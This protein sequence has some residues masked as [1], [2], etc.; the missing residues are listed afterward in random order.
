MPAFRDLLRGVAEAW[1][2]RRAEV[3]GQGRRV[4][5]AIAK[6]AAPPATG[7]SLDRTLAD[8]AVAGLRRSFDA[9]WGGFGGAPKFPQPMTLE[10]LLRRAVRGVDGVLDMVTTTL[11]RM[12]GGGIYDQLGG[13]FARYSTDERWHVPHF[14][15]MLYDNAQLLQ[16]YTRAW[17]VT[18]SSR[19][20]TVA[21]ETAEYLLRE[22]QHPEGGFTPRRT[23]TRGVEGRF[24]TWSWAEPRSSSANRSRGR[25]GHARR[26]TGPATTGR[27]TCSGTRVRAGRSAPWISTRSISLPRSTTRG[28]CCMR[29]VRRVCGPRPTTRCSPPGTAWRSPPSQAGRALAEPAYTTAAERERRSSS[30]TFAERTAACSEPGATGCARNGLRRRPCTMASACLTLYETTFE[31]SWFERARELADDLRRLFADRERGGFFQTGSDAEALVVRPKDLYDN[32][33]PSGNSAAADLLRLSAFTGEVISRPMPSRR[34]E[35]SA[36]RSNAHPGLR[37]SALRPRPVD[38]PAQPGR[39]RGRTRGSRHAVAGVGGEPSTVPTEPGARRARPDDAA[40]ERAVPLLRGR[41]STHGTAT[42]YVCE[43]FSCRLPVTDPT[44]LTAQL[45]AQDRR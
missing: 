21:T 31:L 8:A 37:T 3:V 15:K 13:G 10:F 41:S 43:G 25:S 22:M 40:A 28:G 32:A 33:T 18:G 16:L 36:T 6:A 27:R 9:T 5:Q 11:D 4:T 35:P 23:P 30:S 24:F 20:R 39:D 44:A 34:S 19:Y 42:A 38:R 14:E 26:A 17:Q 45:D 7:G 2:E 1:R 12:A 29:L